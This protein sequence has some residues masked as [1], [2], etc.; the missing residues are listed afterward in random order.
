MELTDHDIEL[1]NSKIGLKK[2][3][4]TKPLDIPKALKATKYEVKLRKLQEKLIG[5]QERVIQN[6]EKIVI[7]F[8]GRDSAGK[9]GAIRRM[10]ARLNPRH[11]RIVALPKP[12]IEEKGQWY[13]QRYVNHLPNPGEM[14]FFD[15]SWYNRAVVEPAMKFCTEK[16]Y[17]EFMMQ[18]NSFEKMF[19]DS[20]IKLIKLYF[21]ITKDEQS[22][23]FEELRTD[24]LK[25][26]KLSP[27]DLRAHELWDEFTKYKKEMFAKTDTEQC[28]W[29]IIEANKKTKARIEAIEYVLEQTNSTE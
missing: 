11:F 18:V 16:Q 5:L 1:L 7:L 2:L 22:R 8:E 12:S 21:S 28:P 17:Q 19:T 24:S 10:T 6:N 15:R 23:R 3:L 25:K 9:G 27:V 20:G 13:F 14:V 4:G 26:W 29:K